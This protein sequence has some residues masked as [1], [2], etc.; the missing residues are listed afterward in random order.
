VLSVFQITQHPG[1]PSSKTVQDRAWGPSS[2]LF[3]KYRC[4]FTG[5]KQSGR[6]VDHSLPTTASLCLQGAARENCTFY[7]RGIIRNWEGNGPG[8]I[9]VLSR[10]L[11]SD[12]WKPH[13]TSEGSQRPVKDSNRTP[14]KHKSTELL[15]HRPA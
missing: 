5:V 15:L 13:N 4:S 10:H 6:E 3:N 14:P 2:L 9:D 7:S 12:W 8:P 1:F 11:W